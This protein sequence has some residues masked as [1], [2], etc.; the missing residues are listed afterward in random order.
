MNRTFWKVG[1]MELENKIT[2][3]LVM[4]GCWL[5]SIAIVA[6]A[7]TIGR[8]Q[9]ANVSDWEMVAVGTLFLIGIILVGRY[10]AFQEFAK[11]YVLA[12]RMGRR[13]REILV[14]HLVFEAVFLVVSLVLTF[15]LYRLELYIYDKLG[16]VRFEFSLE[17][18]FAIKP[19]VCLTI[20]LSV[21]SMFAGALFLWKPWVPWI[22]WCVGCFGVSRS[23]IFDQMEDKLGVFYGA[24]KLFRELPVVG[25]V[26]IV[27]VIAIVLTVVS[28]KILYSR[29][30]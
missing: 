14:S 12:V 6:I 25:E 11:Q 20:I 7:A 4:L 28:K 3:L 8:S 22:F 26:I 30:L 29:N 18:F 9:G 15:L 17:S 21:V 10:V 2:V 23:Q 1:K 5:L 24:V 13:K 27:L 19:L 16:L